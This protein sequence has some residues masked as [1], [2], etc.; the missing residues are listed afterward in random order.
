MTKSFAW[1]GRSIVAAALAISAVGVEGAIAS[2][3]TS[4]RETISSISQK[5]ITP[6]S[7]DYK[8]EKKRRFSWHNGCQ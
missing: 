8:Q 2:M 4:T 3:Y 7:S 6:T 5:A 1:V